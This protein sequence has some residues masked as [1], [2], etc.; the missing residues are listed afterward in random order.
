MAL[1]QRRRARRF[2]DAAM[3]IPA[4]GATRRSPRDRAGA[5]RGWNDGTY[6]ASRT[7]SNRVQRAEDDHEIN[8]LRCRRLHG[9]EEPTLR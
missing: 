4:S 3:P 9:G 5:R 1:P 6:N 7:G 2:V 8:V